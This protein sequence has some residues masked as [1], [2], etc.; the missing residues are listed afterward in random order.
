VSIDEHENMFLSVSGECSGR[1]GEKQLTGRLLL[2]PRRQPQKPRHILREPNPDMRL[3]IMVLYRL[4]DLH[5]KNI[6]QSAMVIIHVVVVIGGGSTHII[7]EQII[8]PVI[9]LRDKILPSGAYQPCQATHVPLGAL[10]PQRP[11]PGQQRR[12]PTGAW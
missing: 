8:R 11:R 5:H 10:G 3:S 7:H 6:N 12:L 4:L 9:Y 2:I 1:G